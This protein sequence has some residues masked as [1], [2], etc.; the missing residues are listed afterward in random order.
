ML[1]ST[2]GCKH[3]GIRYW[4]PGSPFT[5]LAS[6]V[7]SN[8]VKCFLQS[9]QLI[10]TVILG[11]ENYYFLFYRWENEEGDGRGNLPAL[12]A[13]AWRCLQPQRFST[14]QSS[15]SSFMKRRWHWRLHRRG[16]ETVWEQQVKRRVW[17]TEKACM[18]LYSP[19]IKV[20][21]VWLLRG[22]TAFM[23]F[24]QTKE[25]GLH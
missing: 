3:Q 15:S 22:I 9:L 12:Q 21:N 6:S 18:G 14:K 5:V 16:V 10:F 8:C 4:G 23:E 17:H 19:A 7:S 2:A 11:N 24:L 13:R 1:G 25:W 20:H